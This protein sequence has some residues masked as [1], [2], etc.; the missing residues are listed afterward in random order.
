MIE[1]CPCPICG[2]EMKTYSY[3]VE[4]Y[5]LME[6]S[7][8]C[9]SGHYDYEYVTGVTNIRVGGITLW[10][11]YLTHSE[12]VLKVNNVIGRLIERYK[13]QKE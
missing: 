1:P 2:M 7:E 12:K 8:R 13:R 6:G 3:I 11:N 9:P 10:Y 5:I 4:G